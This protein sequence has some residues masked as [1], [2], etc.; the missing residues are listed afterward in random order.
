MAVGDLKITLASGTILDLP[1][2]DIIREK[3]PPLLPY[4]RQQGDVDYRAYNPEQASYWDITKDF[5]GGCGGFYADL[6]DGKYGI[7][8][9]FDPLY[10]VPGPRRTNIYTAE[11]GANLAADYPGIP[12]HCQI[13]DNLTVGTTQFVLTSDR[14]CSLFRL[15][16]GEV[17]WTLYGGGYIS[18]LGSVQTGWGAGAGGIIDGHFFA[19]KCLVA[20][21]N[22]IAVGFGSGAYYMYTLDLDGNASWVASNGVGK[23]GDDRFMDCAI[24]DTYESATGAPNAV[25]RAQ[26]VS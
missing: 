12:D 13:I 20:L 23:T 10:M 18:N 11:T 15:K 1:C 24:T 16:A 26:R 22:A 3:S 19:P 25:S 8:L 5:S 7:A 14:L 9:H 4:E 6:N 2:A 21:N 17:V